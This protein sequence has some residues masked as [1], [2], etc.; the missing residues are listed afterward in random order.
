MEERRGWEEQR[1]RVGDD[2]GCGNLMIN[3]RYFKR[4]QISG[5]SNTLCVYMWVEVPNKSDISHFNIVN[6]KR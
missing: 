2:C 5:A 4:K 3:I 1:E 6:G